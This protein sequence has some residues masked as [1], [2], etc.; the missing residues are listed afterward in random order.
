MK[1]SSLLKTALSEEEINRL[2]PEKTNPFANYFYLP[3]AQRRAGRARGL[4]ELHGVDVPFS[5]NLPATHNAMWMAPGMLAGGLAGAVLADKFTK[6]EASLAELASNRSVGT[7]GGVVAGGLLGLLG[8][9]IMRSRA[10]RKVKSEVAN[11]DLRYGELEPG[12][13][14]PALVAGS[15][16]H[17]QGRADALE[18]VNRR[19][20]TFAGN[21]YMTG[22]Q[23]ASMVPG[24]GM[25]FQLASGVGS[26]ANLSRAN[27]RIEKASPSLTRSL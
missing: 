17:Q 15:G 3:S 8:A 13:W 27:R 26:L 2:L 22:F 24:A 4:A 20:R 1:T 14:L 6:P 18:A 11:K 21:P 10:I 5:V 23:L 7:G 12:S 25:P 19:K 9:A 16:V